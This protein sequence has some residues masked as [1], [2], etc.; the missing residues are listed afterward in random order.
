MDNGVDSMEVLLEKNKIWVAGINK[1]DPNFFN[2]SI[3]F[4]IFSST[5]VKN[6]NKYF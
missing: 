5:M 3:I 4:F 6:A 2:G 1:N